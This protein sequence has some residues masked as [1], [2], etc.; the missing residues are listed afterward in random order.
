MSKK[1][2]LKGKLVTLRPMSLKDAPNFCRWLGDPEMTQFLLRWYNRPAPSIGEEKSWINKSNRE[3]NEI[4]FSIDTAEGLHIGT[5]SLKNID[6]ENKNA[7]YGIFIGDKRYWGQGYGTEAGRLLLDYGFRKLRLKMIYLRYIAFNVRGERS[8]K[9]LGFKYAGRYRQG[10]YLRG[11][12][13]DQIMMDLLREEHFKSQ[14]SNPAYRQ[15]NLKSQR[16]SSK[17]K[18]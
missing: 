11:A 13:H 4:N 12:Y 3:K 14:K 15:A 17:V 7:E 6:P 16:Y 5:L 2:I 8:Y 18:A 1:I 10:M 9:K